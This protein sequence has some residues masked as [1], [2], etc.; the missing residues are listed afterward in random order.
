MLPKESYKRGSPRLFQR[1]QEVKYLLKATLESLVWPAKPTWWEAPANYRNGM[2]ILQL[3]N[4]QSLVARTTEVRLSLYD[5][6]MCTT[7]LSFTKQHE[8]CAVTMTKDSGIRKILPQSEI[9][10]FRV[11]APC[12]CLLYP[13][14]TPSRRICNLYHPCDT[15]RRRVSVYASFEA[16]GL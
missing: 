9:C 5:L 14:G 10:N 11:W 2:Y 15:K 4:W 8:S 6:E 16:M 12:G 7:G 3:Q 1:H 13:K